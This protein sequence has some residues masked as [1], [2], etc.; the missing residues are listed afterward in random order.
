MH[1][2][3]SPFLQVTSLCTL[4]RRAGVTVWVTPVEFVKAIVSLGFWTRLPM[5]EGLSKEYVF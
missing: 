1:S 4:S 3:L 2:Y 5:V